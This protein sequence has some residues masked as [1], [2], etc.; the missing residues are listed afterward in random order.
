MAY[1]SLNEIDIIEN[2]VLPVQARLDMLPPQVVE[3]RERDAEEAT[4]RVDY[5]IR[6][7]GAVWIFVRS[8]VGR[9]SDN[10]AQIPGLCTALMLLSSARNVF[11][12]NFNLGAAAS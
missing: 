2:F 4:R 7:H 3:A 5:R 9:I 12:R 11:R 8:A 1:G 10:S 6:L